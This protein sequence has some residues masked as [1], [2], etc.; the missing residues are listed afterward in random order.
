MWGP[1]HIHIC[2]K[3]NLLYLKFIIDRPKKKGGKEEK[4]PPTHMRA[5]V[6]IAVVD[7]PLSAVAAAVALPA[8]AAAAFIP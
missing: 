8:A 3:I 1:F 5:C 6:A 2:R 7:L 4:K